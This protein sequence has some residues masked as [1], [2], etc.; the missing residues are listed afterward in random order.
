MHY[1]WA[2]WMAVS[3]RSLKF[4]RNGF[5]TKRSPLFPASGNWSLPL[6][7]L[8]DQHVVSNL[9]DNAMKYTPASGPCGCTWNPTFGAENGAAA[10]DGR[11]PRQRVHAPN[12]CRISVADTG[13]VSRRSFNK[14]SLTILPLTPRGRERKAT[15][16]PG[17]CT[18]PGA[19]CRRKIWVESEPGGQQVLFSV[20]LNPHPSAS[21]RIN[22]RGHILVWTMNLAC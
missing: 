11:A 9:L 16:W 17:H 1:E 22:E 21:R 19:V 8:Q 15:D 12:C 13:P 10:T 14:R 18:S 2:M 7:L 4:G 5:R 6:R 3:V 20:L